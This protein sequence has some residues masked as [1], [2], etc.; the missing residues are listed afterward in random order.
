M[1]K[2]NTEFLRK[3]IRALEASE[4]RLREV[5]ERLCEALNRY[6]KHHD[7]RAQCPVCAAIEECG[8]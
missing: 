8:Y 1:E 7:D 4:A 3:R 6:G 5:N 2:N